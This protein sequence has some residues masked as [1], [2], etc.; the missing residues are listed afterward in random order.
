MKASE[1]SETWCNNV[2]LQQD[3]FV[4][5][6]YLSLLPNIPITQQLLLKI[7][8]LFNVHSGQAV[9]SISKYCCKQM[10]IDLQ[11]LCVTL[12]Q[13]EYAT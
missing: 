9:F 6:P 13:S 2:L 11:F 5:F 10:I 12:I 7:Q 1:V 8:P 3:Y 4:T